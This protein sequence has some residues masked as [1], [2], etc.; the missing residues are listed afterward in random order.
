[1]RKKVVSALVC[2]LLGASAGAQTDDGSPQL[3]PDL[4]AVSPDDA[5]PGASW[6]PIQHWND[7]PPLPLNWCAGRTDVN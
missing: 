1:M 6:F 7:W 2:A 4:Q 5:P 3:P